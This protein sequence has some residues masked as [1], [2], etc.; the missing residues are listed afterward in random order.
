MNR[1]DQRGFTLIE[2]MVVLVIMG[3]IVALGPIAFRNAMPALALQASARDAAAT[4]REARSIA[5]RDNTEAFVLID[6]E[7]RSLRLGETDA[8]H[9]L[10]PNLGLELVAAASEKIDDN[11]GRIRFFPDGT[12]TGGRLALTQNERK[13]YIVVDW[14]TGRVELVQ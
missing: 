5:I 4:F 13:L 6:V 7:A 3:L 2:L 14:L 9:E 11:Q 10:E 1:E 12:S 8:V